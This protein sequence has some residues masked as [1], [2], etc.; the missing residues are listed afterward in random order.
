MGDVSYSLGI[1]LGTTYTAA[2]I[3][4]NGRATTIDLGSRTATM[5][6]IVF[7]DESGSFLVGDAAVRRAATEPRAKAFR[8]R[9]STHRCTPPASALAFACRCRPKSVDWSST[10]TG[11]LWA[12]R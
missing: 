8:A 2:A 3:Y 5:P 11:V 9:R 7:L 12:S 4:E 10:M 6:S 1:D